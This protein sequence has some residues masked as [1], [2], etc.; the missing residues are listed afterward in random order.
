M[1]GDKKVIAELNTA[2]S[3]ELTA[4]VQYMTQAEMCENWGYRPSRR[5]DEGARNRGNE[6]RRGAH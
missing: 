6:T 3:G 1:Q 5:L 2:L 4:I